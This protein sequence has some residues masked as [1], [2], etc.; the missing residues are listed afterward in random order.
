MTVFLQPVI[1]V[2]VSVTII[3]L[4]SPR[5]SYFGFPFSTIKLVKLVQPLKAALPIEVTE[6]GIVTDVK[7][8]QPEKASKSINLTELPMVTEVKPVQPMKA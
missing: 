1:R 6:L 4:Q 8:V 7:P 5:E 3:A 2:F